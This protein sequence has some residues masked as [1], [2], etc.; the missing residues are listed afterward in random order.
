MTRATRPNPLARLTGLALTSLTLFSVAA[1]ASA[2]LILEKDQVRELQGV[3]LE[4]HLGARI[5]LDATFTDAD[6]QSRRLSEFFQDGKPAVLALVYYECPIVC[7]L[8][9]DQLDSSL[10]NLDYAIGEDYRL[11]VISFDHTETTTHALNR[12]E[13]SLNHYTVAKGPKV[14][15]GMLFMTGD[16]VNIRRLTD[17]VGWNFAPLPNGEWS[18]PVG[19]TI[20][21]P[22]GV[23]ARYIY[24]FEYPPDQL[25]LSLLEATEGKIAKSL[26]ERIMHYCFRYDPTAGAYSLEAMALMRIGG[27]LTVILLTVIISAMLVGERVRAKRAARSEPNT[28]SE[29]HDRTAAAQSG[30]SERYTAKPAGQVH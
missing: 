18:H 21:S 6:G 23:V 2:Q 11:L 17:A 3:D 9:L 14:R 12:R 15:E 25:K 7:N 24:G 10:N 29:S 19:L 22:D 16:Q 4:E 26:G 27:V 30:R 20:L 28:D 1:P 8:V 13:R 5:P